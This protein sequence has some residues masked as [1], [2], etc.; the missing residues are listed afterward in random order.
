MHLKT[1]EVEFSWYGPL[2]FLQN[3]II[4]QQQLVKRGIDSERI[5]GLSALLV[6]AVCIGLIL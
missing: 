5:K 4:P 1:Q 6:E 3:T 2:S